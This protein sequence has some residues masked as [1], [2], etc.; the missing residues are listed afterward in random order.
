MDDWKKLRRQ[1][2][3]ERDKARATDGLSKALKVAAAGRESGL[4]TALWLMDK[5][6][7]KREP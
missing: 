5:I 7:A 2:R 1:I 4:T 3:R 6:E